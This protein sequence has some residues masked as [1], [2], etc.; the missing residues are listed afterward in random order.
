MHQTGAGSALQAAEPPAQP[1]FTPDFI[2]LLKD[3]E[4]GDQSVIP[5]LRQAFDENPGLW[6]QIGDL[7]LNAELSLIAVAAGPNLAMQEALTRKLCDM[8]TELS[9][10]CDAPLHD[11]VVA[12][13]VLCWL[14][15]HYLDSL[16]TQ[17]RTR[18]TSPVQVEAL[19]R[20]RDHSQKR[21]LAAIK[22]LA[23]VRKLVRRAPSPIQIASRFGAD[24]NL[25]AG[26]RRFTVLERPLG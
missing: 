14:E 1:L 10:P 4:K 9:E 2:D 5:A 26:G 22:T 24:A 21:Y 23:T 7:A 18:F 16:C 19:E 17:I 13:V 12:R 3:A 8:K 6:Q 11:L 20:R 25:A 15:L